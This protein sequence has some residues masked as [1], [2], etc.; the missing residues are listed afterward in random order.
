MSTPR[1]SPRWSTP[2]TGVGERAADGG[3]RRGIRAVARQ[4]QIAR[5]RGEVE[6]RLRVVQE[7]VAEDVCSR[8]R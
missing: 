7:I 5:A 6:E 8:Q 1:V 2:A 3:Q 4:R